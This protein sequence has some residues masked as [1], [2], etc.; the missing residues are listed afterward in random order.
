VGLLQDVEFSDCAGSSVLAQNVSVAPSMLVHSTVRA[1]ISFAE[2][3][4]T[5]VWA[6]PASVVELTKTVAR[7]ILMTKLKIA[8]AVLITVGDAVPVRTR[9]EAKG[10]APPTVSRWA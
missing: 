4:A 2:G 1:A 7:S 5:T 3:G 6:I 8:A 10:I 9:A